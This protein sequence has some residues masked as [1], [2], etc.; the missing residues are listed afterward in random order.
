MDPPIH[1][2]PGSATLLHTTDPI[3]MTIIADP[4]PNFAPATEPATQTMPT[5]A[6]EPVNLSPRMLVLVGLPGSG[7]TTF[8]KQLCHIRKDWRR[9]NQDE[10]GDRQKCEAYA[11]ECLGQ[12]RFL[13]PL[14]I[15]CS[16]ALVRRSSR[17]GFVLTSTGLQSSYRPLQP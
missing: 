1:S 5:P 17:T 6:A 11:R 16:L 2:E 13:E 8:S 7:K 15:V 12:V 4:A 3:T 9:V 14:V 10:M